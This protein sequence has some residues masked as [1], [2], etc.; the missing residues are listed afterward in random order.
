MNTKAID[1]KYLGRPAGSVFGP[2]IVRTEG[3]ILYDVDGKSYIDFLSGWCVG[4]S[5]WGNTEILNAM[6]NAQ[7]PEYVI[8]HFYFRP[9][10]ELAELLA[11]I[12]PGKLK[13]CY[14]TTGGSESVEAALQM[15][16]KYTRRTKFL[17]IEGSYH[18]NSIGALSIGDSEVRRE[19]KNLLPNCL[20][21]DP[22]LDRKAVDRVRTLLKGKDVAAFIMEPV[23]TA[24]GVVIPEKEFMHDVADLCKK[25]GTLLIM[26]EVATGFG[27]TGKL[28]ATEHFDIEPDILCMAKGLSGGYGALGATITTDKIAAGLKTFTFYSTNGW[29]PF[30]VQAALAN[31][32][33]MLSNQAALMDNISETNELITGRITAMKFKQEPKISALGLTIGVD[34]G[35]KALATKLQL[36]C[37]RKGLLM[38]TYDSKLLLF[39]AL[40]VERKVVMDAMDI[41][42]ENL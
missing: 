35:K 32:N 31:L 11:K 27:R 34:V 40:N 26:D 9:W 29:H 33:Y 16:M 42:E 8:P 14:R 1:R 6:R 19:F 21:L 23:L 25:Y 2:E 37:F 13:K 41:L 4:N 17:S 24:L 22:P 18:G 12:T 10:A 39:P 5:G 7:G 20:K 36:K 28:F 38:D 3:S 15:A 30:A